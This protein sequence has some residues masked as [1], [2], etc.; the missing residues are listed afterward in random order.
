MS[1]FIENMAEK[2]RRNPKKIAFPEADNLDILRTAEQVVKMGIGFPVLIGNG[3]AAIK[4][5]A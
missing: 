1:S 2:A 3:Q 4:E 5:L